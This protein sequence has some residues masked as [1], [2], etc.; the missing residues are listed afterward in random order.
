MN[1]SARPA[2]TWFGLVAT[3]S[4]ACAGG[5]ERKNENTS[6]AQKTR[7]YW[8]SWK[9]HA[10]KSAVEG[11]KALSDDQRSQLLEKTANDL[12]KMSILGVDPEL[13]QHVNEFRSMCRSC[14]NGYAEAARTGN[15]E[16]A[17]RARTSAQ[18]KIDEMQGRFDTLRIRLTQRHGVEFTP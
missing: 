16:P 10:A 18:K 3:L 8:E 6:D 15:Q 5:C 9:Y 1:L 4:L 13:V 17:D 14:A 7:Q 2:V 11:D 12:E